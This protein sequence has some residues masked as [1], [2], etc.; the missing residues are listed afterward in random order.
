VSQL[1]IYHVDEYLEK[2]SENED[3]VEA[4]IQE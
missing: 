1:V 3:T 2:D 4:L